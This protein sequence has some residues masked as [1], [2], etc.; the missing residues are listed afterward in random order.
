MKA[1]PLFIRSAGL[2]GVILALAM[3]SS[4][5]TVRKSEGDDLA[6]YKVSGSQTGKASHYSIRTNHGTRT[7]SGRPLRDE[8]ATAAHRRLPMG[9]KVLVRNIANGK[10]ELV[11]IT[12]RGPYVR[13][14]ILDVTV[15]VARRLGFV[16]QGVA[17]VE[18][19]VMEKKK[20]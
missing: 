1:H 13:G 4:C 6:S 9:T 16:G 17:P 12:D 19:K 15:G 7:A 11:T 8:D 18:L 20:S 5:S 14:R 3:L 10:T 2:A